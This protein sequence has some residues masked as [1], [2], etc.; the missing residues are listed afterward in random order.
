[1][2]V[3]C[4]KMDVKLDQSVFDQAARYNLV[5][6]VPYL[7]ITNGMQLLAALISNGQADFIQDLPEFPSL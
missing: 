1:M 3:E 6:N 5:M 4:K 7:L 2:L